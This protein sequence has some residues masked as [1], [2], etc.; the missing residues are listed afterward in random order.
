MRIKKV[1]KKI[2]K[3]IAYILVYLTIYYIKCVIIVLAYV[4][5]SGGG[6]RANG[7]IGGA[8]LIA[9]WTTYKLTR[10]INLSKIYRKFKPKTKS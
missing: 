8:G 6:L 9:L 7:I 3:A 1:V 10:L 5:I 4:A 2:I